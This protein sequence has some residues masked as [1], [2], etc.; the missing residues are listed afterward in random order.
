MGQGISTAAYGRPA[1]RFRKPVYRTHAGAEF[2]VIKFK[3]QSIQAGKRQGVSNMKKGFSSIATILLSVAAMSAHTVGVRAANDL[4][5]SRE[6]EKRVSK[7]DAE[8]SRRDPRVLK[9]GPSTTYLKNGLS[10]NEVLRLLGTPDSRSERKEGDLH[11]TTCI[12]E[13]SD[14]RI[15]LTEFENGL[16]VASRI[17]VPEA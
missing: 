1:P 15:L 2:V 14:G 10:L 8:A 12:F 3:L 6:G 16:L 7:R 17:D 4:G 11:L 13:R 5:R 9:I